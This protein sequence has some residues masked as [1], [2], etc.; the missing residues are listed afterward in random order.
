M[1]LNIQSD[2]SYL[3]EEKV[4][5]IILGK[6]LLGSIKRKKSNQSQW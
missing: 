1:I 6:Y 5:S 2:A 4:R 3:N